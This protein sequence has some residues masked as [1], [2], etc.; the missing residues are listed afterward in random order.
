VGDGDV[1]T[2]TH[3]VNT[4]NGRRIVSCASCTTNAIA[5]V[6]EI[7][8]R[9]FGVRKATMTTVHAYTAGQALVDSPHGDRRR[10][11]AAAA[12]LVPAATGAARA[13][14]K[15][16]PE[17]LGRFD[18]IAIRAP[19]PVGSIADITCVLATPTS[20]ETINAVFR[21]EARSQRYQGVVG[22]SDEE[23]VSSDVIG[24]AHAAIVDLT[25]TQVV[26]GDLV[27]LFSWYDNEWGY[28]AQLLRVAQDLTAAHP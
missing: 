16:I 6:M 1:P 14:T 11:R 15:A 21:E 22:I 8:N 13:V 2:L 3:G 9:R 25:L 5:P 12:N 23:M 20:V 10:G 7:L 26:D 28:S 17:L 4:A 27:K 24:D 19:V 18:G